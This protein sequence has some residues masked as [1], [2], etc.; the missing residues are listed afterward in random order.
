MQIWGNKI[1]FTSVAMGGDRVSV[2]KSQI[3]ERK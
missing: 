1:S 2:H 3:G